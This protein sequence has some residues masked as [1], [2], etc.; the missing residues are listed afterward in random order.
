M[1]IL[2]VAVNLYKPQRIASNHQK[3]EVDKMKKTGIHPI[4]I[5]ALEREKRPWDPYYIASVLSDLL[6]RQR[7]YPVELVLTPKEEA[8]GR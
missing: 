6:S 1:I 2:L 7:G 4:D 5:E 8:R 3:K